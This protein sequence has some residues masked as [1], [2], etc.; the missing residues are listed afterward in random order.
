MRITAACPEAMTSQANNLAM[1]LGQSAADGLTF[2]NV[3]WQDG[4]G[5]LYACASFI[6]SEEWVQ[7]A[8]SPL[9]RPE[10]DVD[11]IID[12]DAANAAQAAMIFW[13]PTDDDPDAPLATPDHLTAVVGDNGRASLDAMGIKPKEDGVS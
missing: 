9:V 10:W 12:M 11:E 6:A 2:S 1:C 3:A 13:T 7:S 8:Q 5:N 4:S